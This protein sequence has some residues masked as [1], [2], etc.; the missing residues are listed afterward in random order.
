MSEVAGKQ[1]ELARHFASIGQ[2]RRV[3]EALDEAEVGDPDAWSL[4]GEAFYQLDRYTEGA[5]AARRGLELEPEDVELQDVLAL[6]LI[7]LGELEEAERTLL[8]ALELVPDHPTLLCHYALACA[9]AGAG[10][11][12]RRLV[13]RAA[14]IDPES[15]DVLRTRAQVAYVSGDRKRAK[16]Y[17]DELLTVEPEDRVGHMLQGN[18]LVDDNN[19]YRAV[20]HF[21]EAVRLDPTDADTARVVRHNRTV[22]HWSQWP[23]YPI[24]RFGALKVWG[25]YIALFL[26]ASAT[27]LWYIVAPLVVVYLFLVV[28]SWTVGPAARW[29]MRR[30]L[31]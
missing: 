3:L 11:K 7:E 13:D 27:G 31:P 22:T 10:D 28:Y 21:E 23:L 17:A 16:R 26:I 20:H 6:N 18:L 29:W 19:V 30:K 2:P 15:L 24:Q 25:A 5:V 9:H 8:A 4:R 1:L 12:A 14:S